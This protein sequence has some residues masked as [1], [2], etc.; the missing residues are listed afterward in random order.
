MIMA[1]IVH[2]LYLMNLDLNWF[3]YN[4]NGRMFGQTKKQEGKSASRDLEESI[5]K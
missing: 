3:V 5:I 1:E 2:I 4:N